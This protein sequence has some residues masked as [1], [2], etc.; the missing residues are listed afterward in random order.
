MNREVGAEDVVAFRVDGRLVD[1]AAAGERN[2]NREAVT[3]AS[4]E[5][6]RILRHSCA[7][8]LAAAVKEIF[9]HVKLAIGPAIEDG[10]YYDFDFGEGVTP[11]ILP[12]IE[13]KMKELAKKKIPFVREEISKEEARRLFSSMGETYKLEI[14]DGIEDEK[15]S[16]YRTG[17]FTDLCEGPHVPHTGFL[18]HFKLLS[19]SGAYWRGDEKRPMLQRIYGTAFPSREDLDEFV[20]RREEAKKRDHRRL[21]VELELFHIDDAVGPGLVLWHPKG[22]LVRRIIEDFWVSEHLANGYQLVMTPHAARYHLWEIS[23]HTG[24]FLENM[25]PPMELDDE[26][27]LLKPMNCPFHLLIYKHRMRSYREL[28]LRFAELGTVYRFEK[29]GVLHGLARV[30]GF[31]QDDA[32]LIFAPKD[33]DAEVERVIRFCLHMLR[34]F[35]FESFEVSLSTMPE[36]HI[37]EESAWETATAALRDALERVGLDY[38]VEE[39]EGAFYGPKIDIKIRDAIGRKWQCSTIQLDFHEPE[40]FDLTFVDADGVRKRPV[41]IHRALLGSLERF[42]GILV[43]HYG[44]VFPLWLAPVQAAIL[45]VTDEFI[46]YARRVAEEMKQ[47]GLRVEVDASS[48]KIGKK[49][50]E[51]TMRKV[52]YMLVVGRREAETGTVSVRHIKAGQLGSLGVAEAV[53]ELKREVEEKL[54]ERR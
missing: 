34:T 16:I 5:G 31:T 41:M 17:D 53:A 22:A 26:K 37:G 25:F 9:P 20:R 11:E 30:R 38:A 33:M 44:G 1:T 10:F 32:H 4:E 51:A 18:K 40:R 15:V 27:Y 24:F 13:K 2:D 50:R 39:G 28:P 14:L 6:L 45:P 36:E 12:R 7:H 3:V 21:G 35:G 52:P 29:S 43:E 19:V 23:G 46:D 47:H 8:L 54:P 48:E 49:I 42:F